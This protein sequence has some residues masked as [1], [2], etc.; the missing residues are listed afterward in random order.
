MKQDFQYKIHDIFY[1]VIIFYKLTY[2]LG[3]RKKRDTW[4]LGYFM[5][6]TTKKAAAAWA[7]WS[8]GT[9]MKCLANTKINKDSSVTYVIMHSVYHGKIWLP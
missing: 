2:L 8:G 1:E 5:F 3:K 4:I 6:T 7:E 9:V